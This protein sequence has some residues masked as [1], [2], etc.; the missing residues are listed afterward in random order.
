M[1]VFTYIRI[2]GVLWHRQIP[3]QSDLYLDVELV[4]TVRAAV[5][6]RVRAKQRVRNQ[7]FEHLSTDLNQKGR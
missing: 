3:G 4:S 1:L 5:D 2:G 6:R 7:S